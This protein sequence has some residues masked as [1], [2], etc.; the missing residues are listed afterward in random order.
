MQLSTVLEPAVNWLRPGTGNWCFNDGKISIEEILDLVPR[1]CFYPMIF[2]DTCYSGHWA[3]FCLNKKI[4]GFECLS[5]CPDYSTA[6][7]IDG[8]LITII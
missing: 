4:E 2:S 5:A 3:K 6:V 1:D 8:V 7:E